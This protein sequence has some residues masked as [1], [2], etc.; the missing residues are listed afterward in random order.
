M[1]AMG[2]SPFLG[3]RTCVV[4]VSDLD[5]AKAWYAK[6]LD[7][8]PYFDEPLY[9]GFSV[10]GYELGLHPNESGLAPKGGVVA[11][12]GVDDAVAAHARLLDLG[13]R[14]HFGP[15]DVGGGIVIG[16][17]L[18]PWDNLFGFVHNPHFKAA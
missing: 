10:G 12:W 14:P 6:L 15:D 4:H 13:A 2:T 7:A 9:V 8:E 11:Y 16:A 17:V 1:S 18:D 3:L 5:A